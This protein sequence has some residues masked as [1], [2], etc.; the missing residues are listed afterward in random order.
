MKAKFHWLVCLALLLGMLLTSKAAPVTAGTCDPV[1]VSKTG[2]VITVKATG[3]DDTA[4]LQC[5]FDLAVAGGPGMTVRL[6]KAAYH[7]AQIVVTG[8]QGV[9]KGAGMDDTV[10]TNLPG[11][12]VTPENV[13]FDPP[14]AAN[15]WPTLIAFLEGDFAV[16]DLA[17][18]I[19]GQNLTTGWSIFGSP[20]IM[21]LAHAM[22]VLGGQ[23][24]AR[25]EHVLIEG[26]PMENSLF[27]F[28]LINGIYY[29]SYFGDPLPGI[30][31]S[32]LVRDSIFRKVGSGT[33]L[34]G[35]LEASVWITHNIYENVFFSMDA[36]DLVDSSFEFSF[37][38]VDAIV[39]L[40]LYNAMLPE[41]TGSA[42]LIKNN[43]FR[44]EEGIFVEPV[45]GAGNQCLLFGN[46]VQRV[47]DIGIYL[48]PGTIGC[49]VVGGV[50]NNVLDL[51]TDNIL[52]GVNNMGTGVGPAIQTLLRLMK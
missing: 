43:V 20:P 45:F 11:L 1:Y 28:N 36:A 4:N 24:D 31:G 10:V 30:S 13:I 8:F 48:G 29:E 7:I 32:Y 16:S 50:K 6:L 17:F 42:I 38:Q 52:V 22:V 46:N 44:G 2:N 21:E 40:D 26:E 35:L 27:G 47:A 49:T 51:G 3:L 25:V 15:P 19:Q 18:H 33:P 39:G 14:S 9:F 12:Y 34:E 5:A 37:N 23:A 41:M